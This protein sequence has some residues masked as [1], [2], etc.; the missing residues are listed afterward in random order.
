[1]MK[2]KITIDNNNN[3]NINTKATSK[4]N[5]NEIKNTPKEKID[6]E[7][8]KNLL[9]EISFNV[10]HEPKNKL[11]KLL[12]NNDLNQDYF[13]DT[14]YQLSLEQLSF[15]QMYSN[16]FNDIYHYL[17]LNKNELKFFRKKLIEKC[18][19]NLMNKKIC[20]DNQK[21]I[22]NNINLI[23]ELIAAKIFPKKMGLKCLHYLLNKFD[24][25]SEKNI[26]EIKYI[27]LEC[28]INLIN[29]ICSFIYNYQKERTH[30]EFDEEIKKIIEKLKQISNDE[31]NKD[32]PN[33]TKHL[34]TN[35]IEKANNKW[36]LPLY[37]KKKYVM[38]F[39]ILNKEPK[40]IVEEIN[41]KSFNDSSFIKEEEYDKSF[42]EEEQKEEPKEE[43]EEK[44]KNKIIV[45]GIELEEDKKGYN[46]NRYQS[47]TEFKYKNKYGNSDFSRSGNNLSYNKRKSD[48]YSNS[49]N[50]MPNLSNSNLNYKY[51]N[52]S[53][54]STYYSKY[55]NND[56][57][58]S[59][60]GN[61][62]D[63]KIISNNLKAFKWHIDSKKHIN[64]FK[65]DDI[66]KLIVYSKIGMNDFIEL[67]IDSCYNFY[68]NKQSIYYIDLYIKS[69]FE[70]YKQY[71]SET[72][73][74]DIKDGIVN[75]LKKL[76]DN[77]KADSY[78][79]EIW[80]ILIYYL[81]VNKIF[82]MGDFNN[83]NKESEDIKKYIADFI[84]KI[85]NYNRESK[86]YLI[87]KLKATKFFN[88]NR[89]YFD[90]IK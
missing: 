47:K 34:L 71:F 58:I 78:L 85:I 66:H 51:N 22:N 42:V 62:N 70:Y 60:S 64:S 88:D 21:I 49:N 76:F 36:E 75:N 3:N 45:D 73:F 38:N 31:K 86:K 54:N 7:E 28:I 48:F 11:K 74:F 26:S 29:L 35:V 90:Y 55:S 16:L 9:N 63:K 15:Q 12:N 41:N 44:N 4:N 65:W 89:I 56:S 20:K 13:I 39:E 67:L 61:Y 19:Q 83:F 57:N 14:I 59:D 80:T 23:G 25:Y 82:I 18:K 43:N 53:S 5:K 69:I 68:L 79:E 32:I 37:E 2:R 6:K 46:Y 77:Q 52:K 27:Y 17:S 40:E 50:N 1:M 8:I 87:I 30:S 10:Y 33:Y 81:I 72:D 24:K 84:F